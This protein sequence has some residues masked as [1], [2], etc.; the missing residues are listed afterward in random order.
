MYSTLKLLTNKL[1]KIS[2]KQRVIYVLRAFLRAKKN[3]Y[4]FTGHILS[5]SYI[6]RNNKNTFA[7]IA[8]KNRDNFHVLLRNIYQNIHPLQ[9]FVL[10]EEC[11]AKPL[12]VAR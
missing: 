4:S 7:F 1:I 3:I 5:I 10:M 11:D 9:E 8:K 2:T 6:Y 12:L